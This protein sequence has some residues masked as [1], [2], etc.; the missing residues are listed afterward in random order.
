[1]PDQL[2]E[3]KAIDTGQKG[4]DGTPVYQFSYNVIGE[5]EELFCVLCDAFHIKPEFMELARGAIA[6]TDQHDPA[7]CEFCIEKAARK[8][9]I[10][11]CTE[12]DCTQCI[13]KTGQPCWWVEKDL[14][15]ACQIVIVQ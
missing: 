14:C 12:D 5:P 8:C 11:G 7:T 15:S 6:F 4:D 2:I 13:I 10:C 9:R 1:M 3:L